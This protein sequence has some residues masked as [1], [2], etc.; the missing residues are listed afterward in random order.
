[1]ILWK[2]VERI[3]D[4]FIEKRKHPMSATTTMK[5][6]KYYEIKIFRHVLMIPW[7]TFQRLTAP[8]QNETSNPSENKGSV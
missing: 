4:I 1:M 2:Y 7:S 8:V 3:D 5:F 6:N